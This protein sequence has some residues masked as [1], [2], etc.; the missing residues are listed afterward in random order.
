[1]G[2]NAN[3]KSQFEFIQQVW[4]N[5][6]HFNG[7]T[8]NPNPLTGSHGEPNNGGSMLVPYSG[9]DEH[10]ASLPRLV[11]VP[12]GAYLFMPGLRALRWLAV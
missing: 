5:N 8:D 6:S 1:L 12:G 11:T 2:I 10:T 4:A 9:L 3:I 7:L